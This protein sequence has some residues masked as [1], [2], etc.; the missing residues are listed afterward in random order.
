MITKPL[1]SVFDYVHLIQGSQK[2][3]KKHVFFWHFFF[4]SNMPSFRNRR[5]PKMVCIV[6]AFFQRIVRIFEDICSGIADTAIPAP[7]PP[8]VVKALMILKVQVFKGRQMIWGYPFCL[9]F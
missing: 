2:K 1:V 8:Q 7:C 5:C 9:I 4:L 6:R 3:L